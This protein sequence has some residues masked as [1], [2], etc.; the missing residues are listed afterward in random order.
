MFKTLTSMFYST[1]TALGIRPE[2]LDA[3]IAAGAKA[4]WDSGAVVIT[5]PDGRE[6]Y[7]KAALGMHARAAKW[8]NKFNDRAS[9]AS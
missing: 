4:R 3:A 2:A 7:H 6:S 8:C 9:N 5:Y 1:G